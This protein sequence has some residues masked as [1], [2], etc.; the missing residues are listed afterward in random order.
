MR[1]LKSHELHF[2]QLLLAHERRALGATW[3][4][5]KHYLFAYATSTASVFG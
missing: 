5:V 1:S 2:L 3:R 4:D